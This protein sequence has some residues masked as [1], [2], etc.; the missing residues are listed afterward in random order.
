MADDFGEFDDWYN[1]GENCGEE[2]QNQAAALEDAESE[3]R[4]LRDG[5]SIKE[6]DVAMTGELIVR[7]QNKD[8]K[9]LI[10]RCTAVVVKQT[11]EHFIALTSRQNVHYRIKEDGE[12]VTY[13]AT[14]GYFFLQRTD[15]KKCLARMSFQEDNVNYFKPEL[16]FDHEDNQN[17]TGMNLAGIQLTLDKAFGDIPECPDFVEIKNDEIDDPMDFTVAG[18]PE[19]TLNADNVQTPTFNQM[20]S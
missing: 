15:A 14:Q 7:F 2:L 6:D 13:N 1:D 8:G 9:D 4:K 16:E 5:D 20:W 17:L 19:I 3:S 10:K 18:Y 12:W 11:D